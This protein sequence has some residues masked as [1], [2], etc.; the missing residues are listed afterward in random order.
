MTRRHLYWLLILT[1]AFWMNGCSSEKEQAEPGM[2]IPQNYHSAIEQHREK[3]Q[4]YFLGKSSPLP[5]SLKAG[6]KGVQYYP[7]D[8]TFRIIAECIPVKDGKVFTMPVT[9]EIADVYQVAG[10]F[11]FSVHDTVCSLEVYLNKSLQDAEHITAYFV[12]FYDK[13]SGL[14]TYGGGR[15]L[16]MQSLVAGPTVLDFNLAYQPYCY[17]NHG[18]SCPIPP[19]QNTLAVRIRAGEKM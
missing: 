5:D 16:D 13:T 17:Y 3:N 14:E 4:Q 18:Y 8:T 15:Y 19:Q 2:A 12:P 11:T 6:F 1:A 9:G 10:K 7:V